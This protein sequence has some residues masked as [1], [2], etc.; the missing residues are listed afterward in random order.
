MFAHL[1]GN[2]ESHSIIGLAEL[3]HLVVGTWLLPFEL[4]SV[5]PHRRMTDAGEDLGY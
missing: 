4:G 1:L 5:S 2:G 3:K